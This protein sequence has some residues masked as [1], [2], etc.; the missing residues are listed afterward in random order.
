MPF[1][2]IKSLPLHKDRDIPTVLREIN[3]DF[4][5]ATGIDP[6]HLHA[7]WEFFAPGH[8][9]KGEHTPTH[10]PE[11][12]HPLIVDLLTPDFNNNETIRLMLQTLADSIARHLDFPIN[13]IFINYHQAHS[14]MVFDDGKIVEW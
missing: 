4:A 14:G 2:Q 11:A 7:T 10:Q 13:N 9:A 5:R 3:R 12:R 8:Y 6:L 1:I